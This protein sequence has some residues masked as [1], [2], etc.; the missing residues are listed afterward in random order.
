ME[1]M[2]TSPAPWIAALGHS[3]ERLRDL[4]EPLQPGQLTG[5]SYASEWS[6][7]QSLSHLGSQ[8]EI[9]NLYLDAGLSGGETPGQE[10][11]QEVWARWNTKKPEAQVADALKADSE[12][13]ARIAS[14]DQGQR[15][16]LHLELFGGQADLTT[17]V[18]MRLSE[19]SIHTWDVAVALDPS[20][21]VAQDAVELLIDALG[22]LAARSGKPVGGKRRV[23]IATSAPQRRFILEIGEKVSLSEGEPD[24]EPDLALPAEAMMRLVYGR[25]DSGH[26]PP[27]PDSRVSV[28]EL[29][30]VFPGF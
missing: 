23:T 2:E 18:R 7:A 27:L 17:L 28:S 11:F 12:L 24:G 21:K 29:R 10:S 25:L 19:H 13:V 4:V 1:V 6:I 20:A 5:P 3:Q 26:T 8:A 9:F 22:E 16:R 14:L 30:P 15:E